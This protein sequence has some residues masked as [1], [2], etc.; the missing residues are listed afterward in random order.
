MTLPELCE[1]VFQSLCRAARRRRAGAAVPPRELRGD[2]IALLSRARATTDAALLGQFDRVEPALLLCIDRAARAA[3]AAWTRH[4]THD[5][6]AAFFRLLGETLDDPSPEAD[7]RLEVLASCAA[8]A[9]IAPDLAAPQRTLV[10]QMRLR[11]NIDTLGPVSRPAAPVRLDLTRTS[12][13]PLVVLVA[14]LL[15]AAAVWCVVSAP[16]PV[17]MAAAEDRP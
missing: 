6:T 16:R 9:F 5:D 14:F 13:S 11:L 8:L 4:A 2:L 3:D 17:A 10:E 7:E 12:A 15:A 1:P